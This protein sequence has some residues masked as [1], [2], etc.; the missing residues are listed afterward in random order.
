MKKTYLN[1]ILATTT[2]FVALMIVAPLGHLSAQN[3]VVIDASQK[4]H[5]TTVANVDFDSQTLFIDVD[6]TSIPVNIN[7]ST[8]ISLGNGNDT[9][10]T[11]IR[12]GANVY[13]FGT[14][15]PI[16]K[17]ITASKIVLRNKSKTERTSLSRAER[18]RQSGT[19]AQAS[20]ED[21]L[22]L[23]IK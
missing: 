3:E 9:E 2:A 14:Y 12:A 17:S 13:V 4:V 21:S 19:S 7:A 15:D 10:F 18:E 23:T 16:L 11:A 8:T 6:G 5:K 22:G 1:A 20:D